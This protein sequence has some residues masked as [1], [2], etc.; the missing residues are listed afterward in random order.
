ML[1][2]TYLNK[3]KVSAFLTGL[4]NNE[5]L[6]GGLG[7]DF[8]RNVSFLSIQG[9]GNSQREMLALF[10][11]F[12][13]S[14]CGFGIPDCGQSS[15]TFVYIDDC[16]FTG[17][18]VKK[19]LTAWIKSSAPV[20]A[21]IHIITISFARGGQ[22]YANGKIE[23][24]ATE[25]KKDIDVHWWRILE[26]EDRKRY[27]NTSD[28]LK[29][30][31][32]GEDPLVAEYVKSLKYGPIFRSVDG[33][34]EHAYFSSE[35]ARALLEQEFLKAGVRIRQMCPNLNEFQRPL[36]NM[37]LESLGFGAMV[38]TFRNCPNNTPLAFWA[39]DPWYPLFA[40]R[41]N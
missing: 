5:A 8:W 11:E 10:D 34:G 19:D 37:V 7:C 36:G 33:V 13:Q 16:I 17:N 23:A 1:K 31:S 3:Q 29:P 4:I 39:G 25:A 35:V 32:L 38:V 2:R 24:A 27:L 28:L 26:L 12:L 20:K 22:W 30:R 18:R 6:T 15:E 9:G 21:T 40:R 14:N 41:A